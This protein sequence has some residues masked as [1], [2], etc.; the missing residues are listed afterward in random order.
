MTSITKGSG[1]ELLT[2]VLQYSFRQPDLLNRALTHPSAV[3]EREPRTKLTYD[4]LEFLGDRVLAIVVARLLY[5]KFPEAPSGDLARRF[6]ELVRRETLAEVAISLNLG[7]YII[8]GN[9]DA[10]IGG[11]ANPAILADVVEAILAAIYLDGGLPAAVAFINRH[12]EDRAAALITPPA[13]AKTALQEWAQS[14]AKAPPTYRVIETKGPPHKPTF[15]VAVD[16]DGE[17]ST[18]GQGSTKRQAEQMAA[19][20]MLGI[21]GGMGKRQHE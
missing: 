13:D 16:V 21:I 14:L 10:A 18:N 4:R 12:W 5:E 20:T 8:M 19:E 1:R 9:A 6:N 11:A 2:G 15:I 7:A 3:A 17:V